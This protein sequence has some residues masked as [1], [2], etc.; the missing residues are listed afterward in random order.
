MTRQQNENGEKG[1]SRVEHLKEP[2][3]LSRS[4]AESLE[5]RSAVLGVLRCLG[6]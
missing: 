4:V 2:L 5:F 1:S 6:R 3:W